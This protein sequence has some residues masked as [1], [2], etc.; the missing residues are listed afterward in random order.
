MDYWGQHLILDVKGCDV[1]K[2]TDA[3][4][5]RTFTKD[6]VKKIDMVPYGEPQVVHFADGTELAGWTVTQLIYTS[7][8]TGHFL[9]INGDLYLDV[10][11]CKEFNSQ[12]VI[13]ILTEYFEPEAI[14]S[15]LLYRRA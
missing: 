4:Y 5:I 3:D 14:K 15:T 10:F 9:D 2:V 6:L 8:I 12:D 11:S 1:S 7:N 13:D